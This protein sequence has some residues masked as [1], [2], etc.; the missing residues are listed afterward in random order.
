LA[1][2]PP[3]HGDRIWAA[4]F[5]RSIDRYSLEQFRNKSSC[6]AF[7]PM[8]ASFFAGEQSGLGGFHGENLC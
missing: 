2:E 1:I 7:D 6:D 3:G 8:A 5:A 4:Y